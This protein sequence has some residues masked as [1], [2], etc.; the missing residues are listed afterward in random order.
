[1]HRLACSI[2]ISTNAGFGSRRTKRRRP[3]LTGAMNEMPVSPIQERGKNEI[4]TYK[5]I[6]F[7]ESRLHV[8]RRTTASLVLGAL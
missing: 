1:M 7:E 6:R 3:E 4:R 8:C 2:D 5:H